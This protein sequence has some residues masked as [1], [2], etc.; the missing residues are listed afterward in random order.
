M[1]T[2]VHNA[3]QAASWR[4]KQILR[5]QLNVQLAA[6]YGVADVSNPDT[7]ATMRLALSLPGLQPGDGIMLPSVD[8]V[9]E[10]AA[11]QAEQYQD[12][13]GVA[14]YIGPVRESSYAQDYRMTASG[15][16]YHTTLP[17]AA[18]LVFQEAPQPVVRDADGVVLAREEI[19]LR[20][21]YCYLGAL[22]HTIA[23][24][25]CQH[26]AISD[27]T[28]LTDYALQSVQLR[29]ASDEDDA[30]LF[31]VCWHEVALHQDTVFPN[32]APLP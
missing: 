14:V 21:G 23:R 10:Q 24:Y 19:M 13:T 2:P 11:P 1:S 30:P 17:F 12:A 3:W 31:G 32:H 27:T 9:L 5:S 8:R 29:R 16:T 6:L 4:L 15:N 22:A 25:G 18:A 28:P 26:A 20:R 7:G